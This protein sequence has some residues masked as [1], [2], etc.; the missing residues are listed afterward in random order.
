M[1]RAKYIT[2]TCACLLAV[3]IIAEIYFWLASPRASYTIPRHIRYSFTLRNTTNRLLKGI[4]FWTYA[5]VRQTATQQCARL[6]ASHPYQLFLDDLGNQILRFTFGEFAPYATK[7]IT[8]EVDL[9]LAD[10]P[11]STQVKNLA[12][13]LQAD[14][15]CESDDQE[16][17]ALAKQLQEAKAIETAENIFRWVAGHTHYAGYLKEPRGARYALKQRRGDCTEF[18]YL[19]AALCR[20]S[21]IPA[22]GI[23]GYVCRENAL[24]HPGDYHNWV[25]FYA[26]GVW[27][28]ADPQGKGF[29]VHPS[30]YIAMQVLGKASKSPLNGHHRFRCSAVGVEVTMEG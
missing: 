30:H 15:Y 11:N 29:L 25:E 6:D 18:M 28:I 17:S 13:Y 21:K 23:A 14:P 16:I 10:S 20:A 4:E 7:V 19:F 2:I 3:W 27:K 26:D 5:P 24:L 9:L 22:R 12:G 8:I 1:R